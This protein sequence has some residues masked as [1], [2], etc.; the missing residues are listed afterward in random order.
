M[1]ISLVKATINDINEIHEIQVSSFKSL[2][3][4]YQDYNMNPGA[5]TIDKVVYKINQNTTDYYIIKE[6]NKSVGI[7][8]ICRLIEKEQCRISPIG[9]L[10]NY[11]NRGIAQKVFAIIEEMYSPKK[12]WI[13]D[14]IFEEKSNCYLYEKIGYIKTGKIEF[15]KPGMSIVYYEKKNA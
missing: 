7:I 4:K 5:E 3:D 13:L 6:N 15:I 11:Q 1:N 12:G 10:P 14:T 2:L 9:I 8:R